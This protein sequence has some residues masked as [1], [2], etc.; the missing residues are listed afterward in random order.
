MRIFVITSQNHSNWPLFLNTFYYIYIYIYIYL[1]LF[2]KKAVYYTY[3]TYCLGLCF[4][5][6]SYFLRQD[7]ILFY[8]ILFYSILFYSILFYSILFYIWKLPISAIINACSPCASA[9]KWVRKRHYNSILIQLSGTCAY[10][11]EIINTKRYKSERA[12]LVPR[13]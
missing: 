11:Y 10:R 3:Y 7:S 9:M 8:S 13:F 12:G 2:F 4:V 6:S 5:G 1:Y